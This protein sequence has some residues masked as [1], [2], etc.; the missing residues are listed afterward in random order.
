MV[1]VISDEKNPPRLSQAALIGTR[2]VPPPSVCVQRRASGLHEYSIVMG[3]SI[4]RRRDSWNLTLIEFETE[5]HNAAG[6][7]KVHLHTKPLQFGEQYGQCPSLR[8]CMGCTQLYYMHIR[9]LLGLRDLRYR[10]KAET[11]KDSSGSAL[12]EDLPVQQ[13]HPIRGLAILEKGHLGF[14]YVVLSQGMFPLAG[15]C[16]ALYQQVVG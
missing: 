8:T 16:Q 2:K 9:F 14:P 6:L 3:G 10:P 5:K 4:A 15:V 7:F 11:G 1:Q 13:A 12:F